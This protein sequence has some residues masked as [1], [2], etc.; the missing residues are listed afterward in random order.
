MNSNKKEKKAKNKLKN[1]EE[2]SH[3][4]MAYGFYKIKKGKYSQPCLKGHL[5][6]TNHS[7]EQPNFSNS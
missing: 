5:F 6:I 2:Y 3:W 7:N 4:L 1:I